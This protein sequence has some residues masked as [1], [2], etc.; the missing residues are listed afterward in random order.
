MSSPD[1]EVTQPSAPGGGD[2]PRS[3]AR[4]LLY[5]IALLASACAILVWLHLYGNASTLLGLQVA[6]LAAAISVACIFSFRFLRRTTEVKH[7]LS[8][9]LLHSQD[10]GIGLTSEL[11]ALSGGYRYLFT[12]NPIPMWIFDLA[13]LRFVEVNDAAVEHYGYSLDEF[14]GMT[15][16]GIRDTADVA[17]QNSILQKLEPGMNPA[18]TWRHRKK[19]GS[20]ISVQMTSRELLWK[21]VPSRFVSAF[22][23]T[24]RLRAERDTAMTNLNLES[25]VRSR[26]GTLNLRKEELEAVNKELVAFSQS[27]SHDLRT[28]LFVINTFAQLLIRDHGRALT[29]EG[30]EYL[31]KIETGCA[32]MKSLIDSLLKLADVSQQHPKREALDLSVLAEEVAAAYRAQDPGRQVTLVIEPGIVV[33]ADYR[34]MRIALDNLISNAWKYTAKTPHPRIEIGTQQ[35]DDDE[36][37]FVRDNG[38]GFDMGQAGKLF[39]TFQRLHS[40]EE[41]TGH[42]IGLST[43][44]RVITRH[45]GRIW[46]EAEVGKGAAFFFTLGRNKG[47]TTL[48]LKHGVPRKS[49][50][51]V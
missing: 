51:A 23:V 1:K 7:K 28:P 2:Y 39:H 19:D 30:M 22:D 17:S 48:P 43:V 44:Q 15:V 14:M 29:D 41:F 21:G 47:D 31:R 26:T 36:V 10:A 35:D 32:W 12:A 6:L 34:L 8:G 38:A 4:H 16:H 20:L 3:H 42:G 18:G 37:I 40:D 33:K 13:T 46:A 50:I 5:S 27:A 9:D 11:E 45:G 49:T 25:M 24:E